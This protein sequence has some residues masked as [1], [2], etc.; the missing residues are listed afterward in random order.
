MDNLATVDILLNDDDDEEEEG[1]GGGGRGRGIS[2]RFQMGRHK[3]CKGHFNDGFGL[4]GAA[5]NT[6]DIA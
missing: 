3:G 4:Q 5:E 6:K 1:G 2:D